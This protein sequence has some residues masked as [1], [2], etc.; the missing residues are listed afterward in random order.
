MPLFSELIPLIAYTAAT[1]FSDKYMILRKSMN[2]QMEKPRET[3][4]PEVVA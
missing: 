2:R 1:V 3:I 4:P